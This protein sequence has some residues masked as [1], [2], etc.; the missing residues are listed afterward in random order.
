MEELAVDLFMEGN[1]RSYFLCLETDSSQDLPEPKEENR[2]DR[3]QR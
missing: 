2:D 3:E 1:G